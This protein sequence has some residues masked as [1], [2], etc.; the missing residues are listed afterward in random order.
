MSEIK[1]IFATDIK[2]NEK[3]YEKGI[4]F[5][6]SE[7]EFDILYYFIDT[8]A[9]VKNNIDITPLKNKQNRIAVPKGIENRL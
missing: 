5:I 1:V 9:M 4:E 6:I 7:N 2:R 8:N 3:K